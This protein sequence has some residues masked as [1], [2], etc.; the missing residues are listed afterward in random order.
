VITSNSEINSVLTNYRDA[1]QD[2]YN[3]TQALINQGMPEDDAAAQVQ[4]PEPLASDP[5]LQPF[6]NAISSA[7]KGIYH[8]DDWWFN[9]EPPELA[10]TLTTVRRAQIMS[11]LN[12]D[13]EHM[14]ETALSAE[15]NASDLAGAEGALLTAWATY[16][17]AP[18]NILANRVYVQALRKNAYMQRSNQIRNYYLTVAREIAESITLEV[19]IDIK[20][21][22]GP[23]SINLG[24][25]GVVPVA[26]LST[27]DFDATTAVDPQTV[28]FA[29]TAPVKWAQED[30]DGDGYNDL[31]LHFDTQNLNLTGSSTE[32]TLTG[33]TTDG[34]LITGTD[35]VRIVPIKGKK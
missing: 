26:I 28:L 5:Y 24:S 33:Q 23:N 22:G 15:L 3:S 11:E 2:V 9:G 13:T 12:G 34:F 30:V 29:D 32:A 25:K 17:A 20:P 18:D 19:T 21:G 10:S 4:L 7:V 8:P 35:L 1:M 14:L 16:Q 27:P 6:S 31:I